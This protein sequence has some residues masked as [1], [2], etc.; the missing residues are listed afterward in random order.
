[1]NS[2]SF[3]KNWKNYLILPLLALVAIVYYQIVDFE[4]LINFDDDSLILSH[5]E[6]KQWNA[7]QLSALF[8]S[9]YEG[10]Y[11][12]FT[13]LT[14]MIDYQIYGLDAG[15]FHLS[16]LIYHLIN[17]FLVF[18]FAREVSKRS[19]IALITALLFGL[20][21]MHVENVAWVASRK[22]LIMMLFSLISLVLYQRFLNSR[23]RSFFLMSMLFAIMAM[24]SKVSAI[25]LPILFIA[26]D[27]LKDRLEWKGSLLRQIPLLLLSGVLV[28]VNILAQRGYGIIRAANDE[29]GI[30]D[31]ISFISYSVF[32]YLASFLVPLDLSPKNL[33]P[34]A[35]EIGWFFYASILLLPALLFLIYRWKNKYRWLSFGLIFYLIAIAP[36]LKLIPTGNDIVSNRYAY[37]AFVGLYLSLAYYLW[38]SKNISRYLL[39]LVL[40]FFWGRE[41]YLYAQNFEDSFS[42]WSKVIEDQEEGSWALAMAYNERGQVLY[43]KGRYQQ[44]KADVNRALQIEPKMQR[45]LLNRANLYDRNGKLEAALKDLNLVLDE[46]ADAVAALKIR[47]TIY[48]KMGEKEKAM[49]DL[50]LAISIDPDNPELYNN[51]GIVF[52]IGNQL[53]SAKASFQKAIALN[54]NYLQARMNLGRLYLEN[55]E[56]E[57]AIPELGAVYFEDQDIYLN[58]Y[59]LG[60]AYF[61]LDEIEKGKKILSKFANDERRA[62]QIALQLFQDSLIEESIYYFTIAMGESDLRSKSLYQRAQAYKKLGQKEDALDDL[63][64]VIEVVPNPTF[65][66]EIGE[67]YRELDNRTEAC[68]FYKEAMIREHPGGIK[69]LK[70]YCEGLEIRE[71]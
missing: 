67:L 66:F 1:M 57:K 61:E 65:F 22:D 56:T 44:A 55:K 27:Y 64:A 45:A 32:H 60:R 50:K 28:L 16:N 48:G 58:A 69:M 40:A 46:E 47:S 62:S 37:L 36:N 3:L 49:E 20:H 18:L 13:T 19:E 2:E 14:W 63:L 7:E 25:V 43:K 31:K 29:L 70:V 4:F 9:F 41:S 10:L 6:L 52:S 54:Q 23:K 21:P 12:P 59:L 51:K 17:T 8:T 34:E 5:P 42:I 71:H 30:L 35:G 38:N 39:P 26:L 24:M 68:H 53:D 15:G 33:Y 11:H